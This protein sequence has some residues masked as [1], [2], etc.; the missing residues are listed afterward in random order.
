MVEAHFFVNGMNIGAV[1][2]R[3]TRRCTKRGDAVYEVLHVHPLHK[4]KFKVSHKRD[5][6]V[7]SLY[8]KV[9][10]KLIHMKQRYFSIPKGV[11][12]YT[13]NG[14]LVRTSDVPPR[15]RKP[16]LA[17]MNGQTGTTAPDGSICVFL[18]DLQRWLKLQLCGQHPAFD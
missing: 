10:T 15:Y 6:G 3:N 7:E 18:Y 5:L 11:I 13:D 1:R 2:C 8:V 4:F 14:A 17:W 12:M 16:F 9:L